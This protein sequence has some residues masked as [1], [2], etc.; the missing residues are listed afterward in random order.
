[1]RG[2]RRIEMVKAPPKLD[3]TSE[4]ELGLLAIALLHPPLRAEVGELGVSELFSDAAL[5]TIFAEACQLGEVAASFDEFIGE[6]LSEEQQAR[7]AEMAVGALVD[8][9]VSARKLAEDYASALGRRQTRR[10]VDQHKRAAAVSP[11]AGSSDDDA[12]ANVQAVIELKKRNERERR[13]AG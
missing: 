11:T 2:E 3:A 9:P 5:G 8:D 6:R 4:A 13:N 1:M 10:E 12:V 7:I